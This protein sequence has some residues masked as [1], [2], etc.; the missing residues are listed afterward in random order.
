MLKAI[1]S[2]KDLTDNRYYDCICDIV[3]LEEVEKLKQIPHH[4]STTR[5]Q[6]CLNVSYYSYLVCRK[7]NLDARSAARAGLMHD[8]FYYDRKEYNSY[9]K[10]KTHISHS[11]MHPLVAAENADKIMDI[12][13]RERDMIENHM[14][15]VTKE[16]PKYKEGYVISFVDKYC[17][18][19]EFAALKKRRSEYSHGRTGSWHMTH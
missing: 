7:L 10:G 9:S 11:S 19:L 1:G 14:W 17:A 12:S 18:L 2:R 13:D 16:K 8:L 3:N 6:H 15:P 4:I 5:F